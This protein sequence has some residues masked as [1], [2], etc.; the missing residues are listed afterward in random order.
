MGVLGESAFRYLY[1][2]NIPFRTFWISGNPFKD[3]AGA[4]I[5]DMVSSTPY[6]PNEQ[7][8]WWNIIGPNTG[9]KEIP[10]VLMNEPGKPGD[11]IGVFEVTTAKQFQPM[12]DR[13]IKV[14]T[15]AV[16]SRA[17]RIPG[18][19]VAPTLVLDRGNFQ[20]NITDA[21]RQEIITTVTSAGGYIWLVRD[22]EPNTLKL[23]DTYD[24]D[25]RLLNGR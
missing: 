13:A 18:V 15:W 3:V 8:F 9:G 5:P 6:G 21:Q 25:L 11:V 12:M 16:A 7:F 10:A 2:K 4:G 24:H 23:L 22:L 17:I 19:T 20:F 1:T 14:G